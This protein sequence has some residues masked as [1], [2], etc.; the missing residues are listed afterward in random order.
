MKRDLILAAIAL[1]ALLP[2]PGRAQTPDVYAAR[3]A[4]W[5]AEAEAGK[6]RLAETCCR[7]AAQVRA[8]ADAEAFQGWRMERTG[9]AEAIY[10]RSF[11]EIGAVTLDFG[12]HMTGYLT[13]RLRT[14]DRVQ[15]APLR[16]RLTL[17]E[18]PA[19]L[20]TPYD[21]YP[22]SLSRA[23][24]QDEV[25]TV[26]FIE[27]GIT[28]ARRL[29]G[30]YLKIELLGASPDFDF[31]IDDILFTALS[32]AAEPEAELPEGVAPE[33]RA[34]HDVALATLAECMQTVYEDGPKRDARLWIGDLYLESLANASSFRRHD[35]TRRCLYLL[36]ALA[37]PDGKLYANVFEKPAPHPQIGS[38]CLSYNLLFNLTLL[39]YLKAT[40]DMAAARDLWC[41]ARNQMED[42]LSYVD[43]RG[44]FDRNRKG[45]FVWLF[46]DWRDGLEESTAMQGLVIRALEQ[47]HSLACMLGC[48]EEAAAWPAM[49]R[50]MRAAA[51]K[52]LYD[53]R[54]ALFTSGPDAQL[55]WMSQ[56]WMILADVVTPAQGRELLARAEACP[57]ALRP[58]SPYGNHYLV[59]A[60]IRCGMLREARDFVCGYWGGMVRKG[61][62]TFWE[63]YD[64]ADEFLSPYGFFPINSYCHA[65]SCTPVYFIHTYPEVFR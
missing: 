62:D 61:A 22:G 57:E 44:I 8:V 14:I 10:G 7:P 55:S 28:V 56:I 52:H 17:G 65:W 23:W 6:P 15:D 12:R 18:V 11:K 60:M 45:A 31:A 32:T 40:G 21:P 64:P 53:R 13:I 39:E 47:T 3:R 24:L 4:A 26:P 1:I 41:V 63:V 34:I 2:L 35:L 38:Y 25:V 20:C 50:K 58:G 46:F 48:Q 5:L 42:A 51:R 33:I 30:R 54:K 16:F 36:A 37:A 49:A 29:A 43:E 27:E 59:E 9:D 19:E